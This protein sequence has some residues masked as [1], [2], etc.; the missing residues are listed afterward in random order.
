LDNEGVGRG[1]GRKIAL[2]LSCSLDHFATQRDAET[3]EQFSLVDPD[4]WRFAFLELADDPETMTFFNLRGVNV[5]AGLI[6]AANGRGSPTDWELFQIHEHPSWWP[7]IEW[8]DQETRV[9]NPFEQ[10]PEQ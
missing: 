9:S 1:H 3:W 8:W 6:R 10:G 4:D 5:Q 7:R 2:G